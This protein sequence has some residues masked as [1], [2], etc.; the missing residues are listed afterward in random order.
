MNQLAL[1]SPVLVDARNFDQIAPTITA[2]IQGVA[3]TGLD[4]ETHDADRH[5]GLNAFMKADAEGRKSKARPL[6]FDVNRTVITG[7]SLYP[8]GSPL[9]YY[10]NLNHADA[11]NRV[12]WLKAKTL[13]DALPENGLWVIHNGPFEQTMLKKSLGYDISGRYIDTL[14][15]AVSAYSP[16]EYEPEDFRALSIDPLRHL[17]TEAS[18]AFRAYDPTKEMTGPQGEL[19]A[20]F[21]GKESNAAHSYN[22]WIDAV[23]RPYDL[24]RCIRYWFGYQMQT[25]EE[26]LD[27]EVHMGKLA[28]EQV[29][30]Y[31]ADDAF[32]AVK[33]YHRLVAF[34]AR[35]NPEVL[36]TYFTQELPVVDYYSDVWQKGLQVNLKAVDERRVAERAIFAD[37]LRRMRAAI[38]ELLPFHDAPHPGLMKYDAKWYEKN[39]GKYR[40]LIAAWANLPDSADDF[41]EAYRVRGSISNAWATDLGK[42]ES[43]GLNVTHYM[44][45]RVLLYDLP[46]ER[47]LIEKGKVQ[48]DGECRGKLKDRLEADKE[49]VR[50]KAALAVVECLGELASVEQR[51]KLYLNPYSQLIDPDTGRVYPVISSKLASRRL[52][53]QYPNGMQLAKKGE[54]A[55][56]RGFYEADFKDHLMLSCD[57]SAIELVLI[58]EFSQDPEFKKAYGQLP[59]EDLHL[60]AAASCLSVVWGD[61]TATALGLD[62]S[63]E[64]MEQLLK[65]L[66]RAP[67]EEIEAILPHILINLKGELMTPPK[68]LKFWRG[69]DCGKGANFGYWYSGALSDVGRRLG[70]TPEQ[71]WAATE[72]YRQRFA[73]AERWRLNTIEDA[74]L[75]GFVQL[76]DGHRRTRYEATYQW[77]QDFM[78]KFMMFQDD[79]IQNFVKAAAR[80]IQKRACNQVVNSMIQGSCATMAKRS[81]ARL[82]SSIKERGWSDREM[83]VL[84]PIHDEILSSVHKDHLIEAID[85]KREAMCF[86]DIIKTL[87]LTVSPAIGLTFEPFDE[88][89]PIERQKRMQIELAELSPVPCID[90]SRYG[91]PATNDEIRTIVDWIFS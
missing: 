85:M 77:Y 73:V 59:Y 35:T 82:R 30:S 3:L 6:V 24:K 58:G 42:P 63:V 57:W 52:A 84:I 67:A 13:L 26:T 48:S 18:S 49:N 43:A 41:E 87:P 37:I 29:V 62:D 91:K 38:R 54:S 75:Q 72:R 36:K 20:K 64:A 14:Q 71:M 12:P 25:F 19:F 27:G 53:M 44:P 7:F 46:R 90:P 78:N 80:K 69:T 32:W 28:G 61:E 86:P 74:Q 10:I 16:D 4:L 55:Y 81:I 8:D 70:W 88:T 56:V 60:G 79:G 40:K 1:A 76:P 65:M 31:G 21:T 51:A 2:A 83:R 34:I 68:A 15:L 23:S 33:L 11:E 22:G 39:H 47:C 50:A 5:A 45:A 66:K 89:K 9:S 17:L